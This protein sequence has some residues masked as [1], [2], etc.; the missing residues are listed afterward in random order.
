MGGHV[1]KERFYQVFMDLVF[2]KCL[3]ICVS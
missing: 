2:Q 3:V 1:L